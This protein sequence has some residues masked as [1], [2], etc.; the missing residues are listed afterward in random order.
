METTNLTIRGE[1]NLYWESKHLILEHL[2][3]YKEVFE[4][5]RDSLRTLSI[6]ER[7]ASVAEILNHLTLAA[8][9]AIDNLSFLREELKL[10]IAPSV[11]GWKESSV[12]VRSFSE[13]ATARVGLT[14]LIRPRM[15]PMTEET[16]SIA[17]F[18]LIIQEHKPLRMSWIAAAITLSRSLYHF[19][20]ATNS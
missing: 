2:E 17:S 13:L 7:S 15:T 12:T 14:I 6:L 3:P 10:S 18:N 11:L 4:V 9:G 1:L 8:P 19:K 16:E 5:S 20:E